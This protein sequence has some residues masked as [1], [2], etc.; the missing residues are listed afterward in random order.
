MEKF[1]TVIGYTASIGILGTLLVYVFARVAGAAWFKS[2]REAMS[3]FLNHQQ[4]R[5]D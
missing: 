3:K 2:K 5:D 1:L 4:G